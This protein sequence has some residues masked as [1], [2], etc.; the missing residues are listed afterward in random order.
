MNKKRLFYVLLLLFVSMLTGCQTRQEVVEPTGTKYE[1]Y[2]LENNTF[3]IKDYYT[4]TTDIS[5]VVKE[6]LNEM[7]LIGTGEGASSDVLVK[8]T[9]VSNSVVYVYF[10]K[11]YYSMDNVYEVLFRA[12]VVKT[13]TQLDEVDFVYFYADDKSLTYTN[14]QIVGLMSES[15]FIADSD[16]NLNNMSWTTLSLYF[17]NS[18]G[19]ALKKYNVDV[20]YV[21]TNSLERIIIEQLIA[22]PDEEDALEFLPTLPSSLKVIRTMVNDGICYVNFDSTFSTERAGVNFELTLYSIVNSLCEQTGVNKVQFQIN[23]DSHV[24]VNGVSF[25]TV[26]ERNL[27]LVE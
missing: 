2:L 20:A 12:S 16:S 3:N 5:S 7:G 4:E 9:N 1:I 14:G 25:D 23:G 19:T 18:E 21:R 8:N 10:N 22:G 13:L 24:T 11:N 26:F 6:L 27:D 15:D 17:A